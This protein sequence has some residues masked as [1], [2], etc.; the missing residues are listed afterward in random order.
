MIN[1]KNIYNLCSKTIIYVQ[2][3][4]NKHSRGCAGQ[5]LVLI[6]IHTQKRINENI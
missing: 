3:S 4:E 6:I 1:I 2:K 5:N